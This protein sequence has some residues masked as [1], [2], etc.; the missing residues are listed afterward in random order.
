MK[1][2]Y[3]KRFI[4]VLLPLGLMAVGLGLKTYSSYQQQASGEMLLYG[5]AFIALLGLVL[6]F[7]FS[8]KPETPA[9]SQGTGN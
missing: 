8:R 6:Y 3:Y 1:T 5:V 7:S 2:G 4:Y 9:V